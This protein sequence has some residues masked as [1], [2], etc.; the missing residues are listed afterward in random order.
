MPL[1]VIII[2]AGFAGLWAARELS[3]AA[4]DVTVIDRNNYHTFLPL[5][6]QIGAAEIEPEQIAYPVRSILRKRKCIRFVRSEVHGIDI[7]ANCVKITGGTISYDYL[8]IAAGSVTNYFGI[9]GAEEFAFPLKTLDDG[10]ILRNHILSCFETAVH[11][12]DIYAR[13]KLLTFSIIGGGPTGVEFAGALSELIRGALRR[14]YHA[15][16]FSEVRV[17]LL[18][19]GSK[20]LPSF[21][22]VL[23]DYTKRR[24]TAMGIEVML[25]SQSQGIERSGIRL[26]SGAAIPSA[27][28]VWT[29]GVRGAAMLH[30]ERIAKTDA[31]RIIVT[32]TLQV[33][34]H[35]RVYVAGDLAV[36]DGNPLPMTAPVALQEGA[37]A[38]RNIL[39]DIAGLSPAQLVYRD[40]GAMVTIG[41]NSAVAIIRRWKF[42]GFVA[43]AMWLVVHLMNLIGFRNRILVMINWAW[44]Y[45]FF[46][47]AVRLILPA[48]CDNPC[49]RPCVPASGKCREVQV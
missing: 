27:T 16:D 41:R 48:C 42:K 47:R 35:P 18:D 38:A 10:I 17:L 1:N 21:P 7:D 14:D 3:G 30:D 6:Y 46:D 33:P 43:W 32:D 2:G 34:G 8:I 49:E 25:N 40:R 37:T 29:A 23:G 44:N 39:R 28:V 22:E 15:L 24:L 36:I 26:K 4:V 12:K 11:E 31:G 19:A 5:L 20:L 13:R 9:P 45:F